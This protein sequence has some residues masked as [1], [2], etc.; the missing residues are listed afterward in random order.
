MFAAPIRGTQVT[1]RLSVT[2]RSLSSAGPQ[3]EMRF[4]NVTG[5][6]TA[7]HTAVTVVWENCLRVIVKG[8]VNRKVLTK[9]EEET[10]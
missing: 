7:R 6:L 9:A 1:S 10:P 8:R 4:K 2:S 3:R 5:L